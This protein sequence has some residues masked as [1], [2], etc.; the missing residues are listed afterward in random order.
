L[1]EIAIIVN[2][3]FTIAD[4]RLIK[5]VLKGD[6]IVGMVLGLPDLTAGLQKA[7]GRLWPLG[8]MHVVRERK[9]TKGVNFPALGLLP[10]YQ[11]LGANAALYAELAKTLITSQYDY[12]E[13]VQVDEHNFK[14]LREI[15]ILDVEWYKTH[16][17]YRRTLYGLASTGAQ[18]ARHRAVS[19]QR[20]QAGLRKRA[21]RSEEAPPGSSN[22]HP[23]S[24][25]KPGNTGHSRYVSGRARNGQRRAPGC[26][27]RLQRRLGGL[28][29]AN[30]LLVLL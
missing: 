18:P 17:S 25:I 10:A 19:G 7:K 5:L 24:G 14:S 23:H 27:S 4:P 12:A 6:E 8:W 3:V 2:T 15:G 9:R 13:L 1:G 22:S 20:G 28:Q 21:G 29:N 16:R 26:A 30:A 11:G